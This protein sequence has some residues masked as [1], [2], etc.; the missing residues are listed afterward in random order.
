VSKGDRNGQPD[1]PTSRPTATITTCLGGRAVN[2]SFS[3]KPPAVL[4][5]CSLLSLRYWIGIMNY[6]PS[7]PLLGL[8]RLSALPTCLY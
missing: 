7:I 1:T 2:F 3:T 5:L 4:L 8:K 6:R